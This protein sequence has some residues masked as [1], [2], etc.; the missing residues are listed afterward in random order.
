MATHDLTVAEWL[1]MDLRAARSFA[2]ALAR[3]L[4]VQLR[5]V[6]LHEFAGRGAP[7]ALFDVADRAFSLV[8]G[9][10]VGLGFDEQTWVPTEQEFASFLGDPTALDPFSEHNCSP[11]A[12]AGTD[13]GELRAHLARYTT[14]PRRAVLPA[15]LVAVQASEAG[16]SD[17]PLDHPT[18]R[19]IVTGHPQ[20][21]P[22]MYLVD[23]GRPDDDGAEYGRVRFGHTG[24]PEQAWL[25]TSLTYPRIA[26]E[27]ARAGQRLLSPDEWEHACG[28]GAGT[29]FPWG[30]RCPD[31]CSDERSGTPDGVWFGDAQPKLSGLRI[32]ENP[33]H[34]ELTADPGEVRGGDGGGAGHGGDPWFHSWLP[35][36][37]A[38]RDGAQGEHNRSRAGMRRMWVRPAL[39]IS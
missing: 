18:I 17:A 1:S 13:L 22:G 26:D 31:R 35:H 30:E 39:E 16:V 28:L 8:P 9:G 36:A 19:A 20:Q 2:Q 27:L 33:Y 15:L 10:E 7:V 6:R 25:A 14:R 38:Y 3:R 23:R 29:L 12:G 34:L 4:G 24:Q 5:S 37:C 21:M 11:A 32:A